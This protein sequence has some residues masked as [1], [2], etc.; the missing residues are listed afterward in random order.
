MRRLPA[1]GTAFLFLATLGLAAQASADPI[2]IE[3]GT[4]I[5]SR[6]A[7]ASLSF[8]GIGFSLAGRDRDVDAPGLGSMG[9][10]QFTLNHSFDDDFPLSGG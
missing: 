2:N 1:L 9:R 3:S 10:G 8:S 5:E 6:T 4:Y 7:P